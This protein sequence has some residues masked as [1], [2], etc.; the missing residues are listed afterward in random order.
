[1]TDKARPQLVLVSAGFDAYREDPVGSLGLETKDFAT[2][3]ER[4]LDV[5][6]THCGGRVVS[7]LEGGYNPSAL[8]EA[9]RLH[10]ETLLKV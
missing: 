9:V 7:C 1:V 5:A 10:L 8:A 6:K 2:L 3:T 4:V